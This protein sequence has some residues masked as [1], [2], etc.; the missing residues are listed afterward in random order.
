MVNPD[1]VTG[2]ESA[3]WYTDI[4]IFLFV[5]TAQTTVFILRRFKL[6]L[7]AI[8]TLLLY[9]S[10]MFIRF[11]RCIISSDNR[12]SPVQVGINIACHTLISMSM[13]HFVFEMQSVRI[14][15]ECVE[16]IQKS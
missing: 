11:L 13:Y 6:D 9:L 8:V 2:I 5:L 10:V 14:Q 15:V 7:A 12:V 1:A 3:S 16:C 4:L